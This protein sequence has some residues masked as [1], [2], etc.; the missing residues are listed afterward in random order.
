MTAGGPTRDYGSIIERFANWEVD[1]DQVL[2]NA[3][4]KHAIRTD[5]QVFAAEATIQ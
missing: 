2:A 3:D 1:L 4:V 5:G